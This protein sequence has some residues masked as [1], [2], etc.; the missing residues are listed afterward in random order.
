M[1]AGSFGGGA[2]GATEHP[3][4]RRVQ[5]PMTDSDLTRTELHRYARHIALPEV[6]LEGQT[7]LKASRVLCVGAGGLG[8]P[9]AM[10]LAA[11]GVGTLG[12]VAFDVVERKVVWRTVSPA[13]FWAGAVATSTGLVFTGD[14]RGYFMALDA[15]NGTVLWQFQTGSGIIGSPITYELDGTQYVSIAAGRRVRRV[16]TFVLDGLP[17]R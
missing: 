9:L 12:I 11:A 17:V 2:W 4:I 13:P 15:H 1:S 7:R 10:Y 5:S 3:P 6:G 16:Y 8:S 14:M